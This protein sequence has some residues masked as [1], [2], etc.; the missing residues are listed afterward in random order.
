MCVS[1]DEFGIKDYAAPPNKNV[2][3]N[4][5]VAEEFLWTKQSLRFLYYVEMAFELF[6]VSFVDFGKL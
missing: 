5:T 1:H 4:K 6:H 3:F 2:I